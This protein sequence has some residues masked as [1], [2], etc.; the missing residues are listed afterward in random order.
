MR[1]A[2]AGGTGQAGSEAVAT[3]RSRGHDVVVLARST[4]IDLVSGDG[5]AAA[6]DG[7]E[8]IIDASGVR[9]NIDPTGFHKAVIRNLARGGARHLVVLSIVGCDRAASYALY[10]GKLAQEHAAEASGVPFTIA[11]TTQFH[12][13]S[14]QIWHIGHKGPMHFAPRMRTQPVAVAEVGARLV[15]LAEAEPVG[16]R[17][18]DFG[19]PREESLVEMVRAY[20]QATGLSPRIVPVSLPGDF[21]RAQRDGSLLPGSDA[22]LG[23]QTFD[24]WLTLQRAES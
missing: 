17:A 23:A 22:V 13:F 1:I 8:A 7:V 2:V 9:G 20:A 6:L 11:R 15:D 19:G 3:A 12:E 16:G 18:A 24:E 10:G 5:V 14:R 21:G 4:G